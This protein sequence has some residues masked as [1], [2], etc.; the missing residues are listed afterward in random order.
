MDNDNLDLWVHVGFHA[1]KSL[2]RRGKV[3]MLD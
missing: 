2:G 1:G 3:N